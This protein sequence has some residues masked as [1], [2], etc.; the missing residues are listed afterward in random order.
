MTVVGVDPLAGRYQLDA[1]LATG[2]MG[3]VWRGRD[4]VLDRPVAVKLRRADQGSEQDRARFRAEARHSAGLSHPGIAS[5]YDYGEQDDGSSWLVMEL[6]EG[7]TLSAV[8]ARGPLDV[9]TTLDVVGQAA[10]ALEAAHT[11]GVVHRD[12]KP[13]NL[14]VRPDGTVKVTDFGIAYA[15]GSTPLAEAGTVVGTVYYLSPE[16]ARG[17]EVTGASDVYALGVVA[18]E[19]LTGR[20]PFDGDDPDAIATAHLRQAP[21]PLP[22]ELPERVRD[23]VLAAMAKDPADRPSSAGE[24]GRTAV[25][26][27]ESLQGGRGPRRLL[28]VLM[29]GVT[30]D[31]LRHPVA[32]RHPHERHH[33]AARLAA[34]LLLVVAV[35]AGARACLAPTLVEVPAVSTG[36]DLGAATSALQD[37]GLRAQQR[38]EPSGVVPLGGVLRT[39]PA[40]GTEVAEG[41]LVTLVVSAGPT[42]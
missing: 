7:E 13:G 33:R 35:G 34:S 4:L 16:Q 8:L 19:C 23:L 21:P 26:L 32:G 30:A 5:V 31:R 37:R 12:V 10:L 25:A 24:L 18:Y 40:A 42:S 3:E 17:G 1:R 9:P 39:E 27:R 36:S 29:A 28:P 6:V 15:A 38:S 22:P 2:G 41:R 20:R 14:L 11:A